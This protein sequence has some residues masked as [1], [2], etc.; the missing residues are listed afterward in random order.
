MSTAGKATRLT[1]AAIRARKRGEKIVT[2][3]CYTAPFAR[4][5]DPHVDILLVGDSLGMVVY[6]MESTLGVTITQMIAHTQA[7]MRGSSRALVV[8]DMPFGS[9][10][11]SKEQA[12]CN[13]A[14]A[15]AESGC[16]AVKLE[17]GVEMAET[18]AFLAARGIPVMA[19]VGLMP[20]HVHMLGG[21]RA[22]GRDDA[23]RA[24]ILADA[25]AVEQAGAFCV[26]VEAVRELVAKEV[27]EALFIPTIGIGASPACDGQVLVTEDMAG[28]METAPRFV[29]RYG[30][31]SEALEHAVKEYARD[32]RSGAFPGE[33][34]LTKK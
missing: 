24:R 14:R 30:A 28:L 27:T 22:Q 11:E 3:T 34:Q 16:G 1:A 23:G 19:H 26:V 29:K 6:G 8:M 12:F 31:L 33:E 32:V 25:K 5:L 18:I 20:Q 17:G 7:V 13:A 4:V 15:M 9:Y 2:L 10:Q 21:Y